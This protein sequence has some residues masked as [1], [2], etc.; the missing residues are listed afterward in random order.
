MGGRVEGRREMDFQH[1]TRGEVAEGRQIPQGPQ[2][3]APV[4]HPTSWFILPE[5]GGFWG[6]SE[7]DVQPQPQ[8][9]PSKLSF[10]LALPTA[11]PIPSETHLHWAWKSFGP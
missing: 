10:L 6:L 8:A 2:L 5:N 7:K 11:P 4:P 3:T 9:C 1:P